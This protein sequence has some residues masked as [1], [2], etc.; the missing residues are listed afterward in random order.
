MAIDLASCDLE[1]ESGMPAWRGC[2][3]QISAGRGRA[4]S[5]PGLLPTVISGG[6]IVWYAHAPARRGVE[7]RA[8]E[9]TRGTHSRHA[10]AEHDNICHY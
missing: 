1:R 2:M 3:Q 5:I 4:A 9:T 7:P 10:G 6:C 8:L